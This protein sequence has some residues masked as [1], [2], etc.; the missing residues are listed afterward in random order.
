MRLEADGYGGG[1][2]VDPE[3]GGVYRCKMQ[4]AGD[5]KTMRVRGFIGIALL[6]RTQVWE[7]VDP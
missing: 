3:G 6:G 4:P 2:I 1:Q 5:G 7:R